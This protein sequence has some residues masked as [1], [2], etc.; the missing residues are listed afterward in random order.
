MLKWTDVIKFA[1]QG[2]PVP[3][4]TVVKTE[5]E[6]KAQLSEEE[7]R[8]TRLKGTERAH[9]SE[10]CSLF[11]PGIMAAFVVELF[12]STVSKSLNQELVGHHSLNR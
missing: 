5:Q 8:V 12:Y 9:S 11:E 10:M 3:D 4:Q 7:Y 6:W 2:N 1:D